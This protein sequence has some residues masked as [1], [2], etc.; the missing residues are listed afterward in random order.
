M[1]RLP[2]SGYKAGMR[3]TLTGIG[4]T[5]L[6]ALGGAAN[7]TIPPGSPV[8]WPLHATLTHAGDTEIAGVALLRLTSGPKVC[9]R[10][11]LSDQDAL[12]ATAAHLH[13]SVGGQPGAAVVPFSAPRT[14]HSSGC[15]PAAQTVVDGLRKTPRNYM[16][17]VRTADGSVRGQ[18]RP[19]TRYQPGPGR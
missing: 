6:A 1:H 4:V 16:V 18:V 14:G 15:V 17:V 7:A 11:T 3:K 10:I 12:P 2:L 13:R 5:A 8:N 9:W 19:F